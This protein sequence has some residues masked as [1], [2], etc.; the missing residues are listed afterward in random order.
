MTGYK[1]ITEDDIRACRK[2]CYEQI[3]YFK[4]TLP[5][6]LWHYTDANGLIGILETGKMWATQVTCLNDTLEQLFFGDLVHNAVREKKRDNTDENLDLLLYAANEILQN[7]DFTTVGQ[8]VICF[9]GSEDDLG[10]WR[11]YGGGECGYAIGFQSQHLKDALTKRPCSFL[12]PM[13]Y[14]D[15]THNNVVSSVMSWG[16]TYY[17]EGLV[18]GDTDPKIWAKEFVEVF[19]NELSLLASL[20]KHPKFSGEKEY[21]IVDYLQEGDHKNLIFRQKRTLLARH[22][23]LDLTVDAN[24]SGLLPITSIYVGPGP[25][26]KI[27]K[28]SVGDL[29]EKCGYKDIN[30]QL[31]SVPYRVP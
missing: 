9:S 27:S 31:S 4:F 20:V 6:H 30:V 24:G 3:N 18:R 14:T 19:S 17:R 29:L 2:F 16:E 10:Q 11:G 23:P 28:I 7:R 21:R 1:Y 12:V 13:S 26:Q 8:F 22:L 5:E 15:S 25:G